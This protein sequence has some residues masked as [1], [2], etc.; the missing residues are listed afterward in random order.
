M[1]V[2]AAPGVQRR[3]G[4]DILRHE[5]EV[6]AMSTLLAALL[7]A[8]AVLLMHWLEYRSVVPQRLRG[9]AGSRRRALPRR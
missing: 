5:K 4:A 8:L 2:R 3:A 9:D 6:L 7:L 1:F